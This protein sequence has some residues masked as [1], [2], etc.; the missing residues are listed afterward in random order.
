MDRLAQELALSSSRLTISGRPGHRT[1]FACSAGLNHTLATELSAITFA[2]NADLIQQWVNVLQFRIGRDWSWDG[3]A[4]TGYEVWRTVKR[5]KHADLDQLAGTVQLSRVV[6]RSATA[7]V[8]LG[9]RAPQ[10]QFTDVFFFD[11]FDPKP[12][13][14]RHFRRKS[15]S[16]TGSSFLTKD[17]HPRPH[18]SRCRLAFS[19]SDHAAHANA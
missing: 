3:L 12:A 11:A 9:A 6:P 7:D 15:R 4:D 10:R 13:P 16:S 8:P 2:S 19:P 18:P 17:L 14:G 1:V 5:P